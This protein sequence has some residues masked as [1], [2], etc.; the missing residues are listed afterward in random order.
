M[1]FSK[2]AIGVTLSALAILALVNLNIYQQEQQLANG[3]IVVFELAPV[4]PRSLMQGDYMALNYQISSN[5]SQATDQ[6]NDDGLFVVTL[7]QHQLAQFDALYQGQAL[8][9]NQQLIQYRVRSGRVK[10]ASNA[11]FFEEGR[12]DAFAKAKY[13]EFRVNPAGKLLLS[14]ML[15]K[16]FKRI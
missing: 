2:S 4:D 15:D 1:T 9:P 13:G 6:E 12:A 10:L 11:F 8:L 16:D 7:A 3:D 14:N 5:I